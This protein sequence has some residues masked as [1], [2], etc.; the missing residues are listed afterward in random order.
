MKQLL[1]GNV[2][3]ALSGVGNALGSIVPKTQS[4]GSN[5]GYADLYGDFQLIYTFYEQTDINITE[6]G[7][8]LMKTKQI[9]TIPGYILCENAD[10]DIA[11]PSNEVEAIRN[12]VTSGFFYE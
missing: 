2:L 12:Y 10:I 1:T 5:G 11:A 6:H 4:I 3:G 8:P 9:S 7:K